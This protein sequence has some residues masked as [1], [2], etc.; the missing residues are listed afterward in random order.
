MAYLSDIKLVHRDLAARNVL[1]AEGGICKI[2]DF[3][4]TRDV[5]EDDTYMKRS[6]GRV[7]V[8][9]MSLE[10]LADHMY[11]S[12]SDVWSFGVLLWELVTLGASPYPGV[13]VHN[14]FHLLK[15]GY[16]M[17]RP[18]N[19]SPALYRIMRSCWNESPDD[20]PT[21]KELTSI[22]EK[23]LQDGVDYLDLNPRSVHNMTYFT[24]LSSA[25]DILDDADVHYGNLTMLPTDSVNYLTPHKSRKDSSLCLTLSSAM[26]E[27][28]KLLHTPAEIISVD[29]TELEKS[30]LQIEAIKGDSPKIGNAYLSPIR[31]T[32]SQT[33]DTSSASPS[34][35]ALTQRYISMSVGE[36]RYTMRHI[37][38]DSSPRIPNHATKVSTF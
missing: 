19:C 38:P 26:E 24:S 25:R 9:W 8:K 23:M 10:S 6:K 14:L 15:A 13:A 34:P 18:D 28:E 31:Q 16:R 11:T 35:V 33:Q 2:S 32:S 7:P 5:Y 17:Q 29:P 36:P 37:S 27:E 20:R 21:F 12:K 4:L 22:F 30:T 3:G 1:V